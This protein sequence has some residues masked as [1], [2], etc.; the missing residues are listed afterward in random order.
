M[1]VINVSGLKTH[2]S[3]KL[4]QVREGESLVVTDRRTP[5]ACIV[6]YGTS[7]DRLV[8]RKAEGPFHPVRTARPAFV[9]LDSAALLSAE[10]GNR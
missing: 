1:I 3:A 2:L 7:N 5:I 10:R 8:E 6:P 4:K 9:D